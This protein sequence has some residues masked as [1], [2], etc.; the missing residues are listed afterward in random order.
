[1]E[2][3]E[4]EA[5][6]IKSALGIKDKVK[7]FQPFRNRYIVAKGSYQNDVLEKMAQKGLMLKGNVYEKQVY[8]HVTMYGAKAVGVRKSV[9]EK[10]EIDRLR[11]D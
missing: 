1:M 5:Y 3:S 11:I 8:Y 9:F 2:V 7:P 4:K 10:E 6:Y